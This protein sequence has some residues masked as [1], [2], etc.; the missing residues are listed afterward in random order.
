M[1]LKKILLSFSLA[2]IISFAFFIFFQYSFQKELT[3]NEKQF[4]SQQF[5]NSRS[6]ILMI[7]SSHVGMLN[8]LEIEK[9]IN[10]K[11]DGYQ[12]FNLARGSDTPTKRLKQLPELLSLKPKLIAYGIGYRDFADSISTYDAAVLPEPAKIF[13]NL[14]NIDFDFLDNPKLTTLNVFRNSMGVTPTQNSS[15]TS[16]PFFP[17]SEHQYGIM[18]LAEIRNFYKNTD[19]NMNIPAANSNLELNSL[20]IILNKLN[21]NNVTVI[22]FVT[23]HNSEFIDGLSDANKMNFKQIIDHVEKNHN[24]H[25]HTL[26]Q[27]YTTLEIWSSPN[28]ITHGPKGLI[29]NQDIAQIILNGLN[30]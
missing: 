6:K 21:E 16:T 26:E 10:Q 30:Q 24:I 27:N 12:V 8:A 11:D 9:I 7:G 23:P 20:D 29:Y 17:Y 14:L 4:F 15:L 18:S 13:R 19:S 25:V 3:I 28:H 2:I 1:T 22:L 5:D